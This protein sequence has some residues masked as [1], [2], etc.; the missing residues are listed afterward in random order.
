MGLLVEAIFVVES[1]PARVQPSSG[2][3]AANFS[4]SR[5]DPF[6]AAQRISKIV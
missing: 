1:T 6:I 4:S 3:V 5:R 2:A